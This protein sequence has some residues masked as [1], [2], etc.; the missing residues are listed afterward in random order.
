MWGEKIHKLFDHN[1]IQR[2]ILFILVLA[3]GFMRFFSVN[4]DGGY[5]GHPDEANLVDAALRLRFPDQLD[6]Q[7]YSYGGFQIYMMRF[8]AELL[9]LFTGNNEWVTE[10]YAMTVAG[11]V[12]TATLATIS[13]YLFYILLKKFFPKKY[14][15]VGTGFAAF[16]VGFIQYAH[17]SISDTPLYTFLLSICIFSVNAIR[18][19]H[20]KNWLIL[21]VFSGL[22]LGTKTT[23]ISFMIIPCVSWFISFIKTRD[24]VLFLYGFVYVLA[25]LSIYFITSPYSLLNFSGLL[26]AMDLESGIAMGRYERPFTVQFLHKP[27]YIFFLQNIPWQ[28]SP[29]VTLFGFIGIGCWFYTILKKRKD[30]EA[31][32]ILLF[33]IIFFIYV[34]SWYAQFIRYMLP[35][36]V[37]LIF[38]S[39]FFL[40]KIRKFLP[41]TIV[42]ILTIVSLLASFIMGVAYTSVYAGT[43]VR[44]EASRWINSTF[45]AE[46]CFIAENWDYGLPIEFRH[47]PATQATVFRIDFF[48]PDSDEK[49]EIISSILKKCDYFVIASRRVYMSIQNA[50][51]KY[52]YTSKI[53]D[54]LFAGTLGF[55]EEASFSSYPRFG[56]LVF[57]DYRTE[58]T[59]QVYDHPVIRIYKKIQ[60]YETQEYERMILDSD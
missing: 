36:E 26:K 18:V 47:E 7:F 55:V 24:R 27:R 41:Q 30:L 37:V 19:S 15:I 5:E 31:L 35:F 51:D 42:M 60:G 53:Y 8:T 58:E 14:A 44:I 56:P 13:I 54:K 48:E 46:S 34:G 40:Y 11:R 1:G 4:W 9:R 25:L 20:W 17:Y 52:P 29:V 49:I 57:N 43:N 28:I 50:P 32:P 12:V 38:G 16:A 59:I 23:A 45:P 21:G 6:P 3:G 10:E 22:A 2:L 39:I 33:G